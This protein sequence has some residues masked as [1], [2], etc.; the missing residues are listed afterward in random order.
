MPILIAQSRLGRLST[1]VDVGTVRADIVIKEVKLNMRMHIL[2][3]AAETCR[4]RFI[5]SVHVSA[6]TISL[7]FSAISRTRPPFALNAS[8]LFPQASEFFSLCSIVLPPPALHLSEHITFGFGRT[9]GE[10]NILLPPS[11]NDLNLTLLH[12]GAWVGS[13]FSSCLKPLRAR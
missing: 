4:W 6:G 12:V 7:T 8:E 2:H 5:L 9:M 1:Y 11:A 10:Q 13:F 3:R